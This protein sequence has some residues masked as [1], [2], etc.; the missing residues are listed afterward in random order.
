MAWQTPKTNWLSADGVRDTDMN[1]IEGN[2]LHLYN[3]AMVRA[4]LTIYVSTT[5][6][7]NTGDGTASRPYATVTKALNSIPKNLNGNVVEI[8]IGAGTYSENAVIRGFNGVLQLYASGVVTIQSVVVEGCR[9]YQ[10]GTQVSF[11]GGLT[12]DHGASWVGQSTLYSSGA[13]LSGVI[14]KNG[15]TFVQYN[16]VTI[17][18]KTSAA[19]DVSSGGRLYASTIAGSGNSI[20]MRA[21]SGGTLCYGSASIAATTQRFTNTGGRIYSGAQT[22]VPN[23]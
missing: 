14:V 10:Y 11:P 7:D 23:Y 4:E 6:N 1:R 3:E 15:S 5:G 2:A 12:V 19:V 8:N 16:T 20:G 9:I 18:N 13:S 22:S 21:D 17:S